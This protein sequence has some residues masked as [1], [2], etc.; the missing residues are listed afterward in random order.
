ME[1]TAFTLPL[2]LINL[3][4]LGGADHAIV[5]PPD[6]IMDAHR[7][8]ESDSDRAQRIAD[9]GQRLVFERHSLAAR[10]EQLA[11]TLSAMADRSFAGG[12]WVDGNYVVT[13][14]SA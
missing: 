14:R 9:A 2:P 3:T 13:R 7:A 4:R 8:L 5:C 10:A 12:R 11:E 6:M 1:G